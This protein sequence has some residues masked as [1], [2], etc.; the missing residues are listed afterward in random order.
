MQAYVVLINKFLFL[1]EISEREIL[2]NHKIP[3]IVHL[4]VSLFFSIRQTIACNVIGYIGYSPVSARKTQCHWG[5]ARARLF[6]NSSFVELLIPGNKIFSHKN[7]FIYTS[8][9]D[10]RYKPRVCLYWNTQVWWMH[11]FL[12]SHCLLNSKISRHFWS[13]Y[14][15]IIVW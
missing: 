7:K 1:C 8:N 3:W 13:H 10:T 14:S 6:T 2:K 15:N 9:S 12:D 11:F 5:V 4:W